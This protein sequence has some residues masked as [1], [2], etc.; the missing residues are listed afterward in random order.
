MTMSGRKYAK[1]LKRYDKTKGTKNGMIK[2]HVN[3]ITKRPKPK[4]VLTSKHGIKSNTGN[5]HLDTY[6][7]KS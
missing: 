3:K 4:R 1:Y 2:K 6:W 7:N 5:K